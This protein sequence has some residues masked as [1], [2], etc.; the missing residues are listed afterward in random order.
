MYQELVISSI[1]KTNRICKSCEMVWLLPIIVIFVF[2]NEIST[3]VFSCYIRML[4]AKKC[5]YSNYV[6]VCC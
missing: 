1:L 4:G 6:Q 3:P 5:L 2:I